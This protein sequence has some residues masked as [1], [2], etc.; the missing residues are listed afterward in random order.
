[1]Q[2]NDI[3]VRQDGNLSESLARYHDV[4]V[5]LCGRADLRDD[6]TRYESVALVFADYESER[7]GLVLE[8]FP[9]ADSPLHFDRFFES[10]YR[11]YDLRF[12]YGAP[13]LSNTTR[14]LVWDPQSPVFED[15]RASDYAARTE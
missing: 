12:D 14:R 1:M 15:P 7:E 6:P 10:V 9:A 2:R 3:A 8:N 13:A 11:Q 4:L 5:R